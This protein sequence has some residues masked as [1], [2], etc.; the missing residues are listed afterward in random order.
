MTAVLVFAAL[1][2]TAATVSAQDESMTEFVPEER[3]QQSDGEQGVDGML[4]LSANLNLVSN[5]NVVGQPDGFS[6]LFGLGLTGGLDYI[7]GKHE[8]RNTLRINES[9]ARTPA[10]E[11]FVKNNDNLELESLYNY[12]IA[13]WTGAFARVNFET[14]IFQTNRVTQ[15]QQEYYEDQADAGNPDFTTDQFELSNPFKPFSFN[16]S[17][18]WFIEPLR[19]PAINLSARIGIGARQTISNNVRVIENDNFG[20]S[21]AGLTQVDYKTLGNIFQAGVEGFVGAE[22]GF[23]EANITYNL[24]VSALVP[25]LNN[26]PQDRSAGE[27]TRVGVRAGVTFNMFEWLSADYVL[28]LTRDPQLIDD[29]QIQN[30]F[31]LTFKYAFIERDKGKKKK[32]EPSL[33]KQLQKAKKEADQAD[34]KVEELE[35]KIEEQKEEEQRQK[36]EEQRQ[37]E[38]ERQQQQ[39]DSEPPQNFEEN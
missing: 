38:L 11:Q 5:N 22:G 28:R 33:E 2:L 9:W 37:K 1:S 14:Q 8:L 23:E 35:E 31:L 36:E 27:L 30:S 32:P 39:Q 7:S 19:E 18:G 15:G 26:D 29:V 6:T 25:F 16:Q 4:S 24:G 10:I 13:K 21:G 20:T 17:G 34:E 3:Q 12:F